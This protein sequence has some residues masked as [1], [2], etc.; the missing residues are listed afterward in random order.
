[1]GLV[2]KKVQMMLRRIFEKAPDDETGGSSSDE[3]TTEVAQDTET[4]TET[5]VADAD[6]GSTDE[7]VD[8]GL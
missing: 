4:E 3:P 8:E 2:L 6:A 1:M 5:E 7:E